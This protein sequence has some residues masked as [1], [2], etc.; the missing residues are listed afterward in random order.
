MSRFV[1]IIGALAIA[2]TIA[3]AALGQETVKRAILQ[4]ADVP[5]AAVYETVVGTA[6]IAPGAAIGAHAHPGIEMG[7][8]LAGE[9]D[10]TVAGGAPKRLKQGESYQIPAGVVHDARN[11]GT[12]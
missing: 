8:V 3:G 12:V 10:L 6:E 2:A 9:I 4:R 11:V 1:G 7:Y 5:A